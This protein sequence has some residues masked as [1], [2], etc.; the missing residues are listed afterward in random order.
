MD[1]NQPCCLDP[2]QQMSIFDGSIQGK[3]NRIAGI[4]SEIQ[5]A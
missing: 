5:Q 4:K 3:T 1:N 2:S